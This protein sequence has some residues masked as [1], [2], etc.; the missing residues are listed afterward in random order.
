DRGEDS[1]ARFLSI[2]A[3]TLWQCDFF[4]HKVR[5]WGGWKDCLV[6]AFIHVGTRRVFVSPCTRKPDAAWVQAQAAAFIG[7]LAETAQ[8]AA[9]TI[10]FRDRDGK[11]ASPFDDAL[12]AAGVDARRTPVRSPNM[13]AFIE[14]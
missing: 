14:R 6:L 1:W 13:N 9:V 11:Y 2:H 7:H 12:R 8:T 5:T 3:A 4:S 10:L